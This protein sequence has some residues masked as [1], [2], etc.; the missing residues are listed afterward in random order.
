M[1]GLQARKGS[2]LADEYRHGKL[3]YAWSVETR[4]WRRLDQPP[5]ETRQ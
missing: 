3:L 2:V 5:A 1:D 4:L